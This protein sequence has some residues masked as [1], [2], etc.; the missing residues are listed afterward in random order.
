MVEGM[1]GHVGK[2]ARHSNDIL[3][4]GNDDVP[5]LSGL[6]PSLVGGIR[7]EDEEETQRRT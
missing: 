4:L 5:L 1:G 2:G 7:S 6:E 3:G